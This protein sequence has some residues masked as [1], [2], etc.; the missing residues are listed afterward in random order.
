MVKRTLKT[1]KVLKYVLSFSYVIWQMIKN[2]YCVKS[3]RIRSYSGLHLP[4]SRTEYGEI[5]VSL[6]IQSVCEEMRNRMTPNTD[7]FHAMIILKL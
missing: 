4:R 5:R 1:V 6:R 7:N 3:V 2:N